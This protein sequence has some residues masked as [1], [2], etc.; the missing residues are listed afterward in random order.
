MVAE[1]GEFGFPLDWEKV[2]GS[3]PDQALGRPHIARVM[4][5]AG[6]VK[7]MGEVF[8]KY[9]GVNG[10]AYVSHQRLTPA[11]AV[12]L[13]LK[14]GGLPVLAHPGCGSGGEIVEELVEAGL[15]GIEAFHSRHTP[16]IIDYYLEVAAK[17]SLL[18]TGGSD[19]HGPREGR[20]ILMG[21]V[22]VPYS[23]VEKMYQM[24]ASIFAESLRA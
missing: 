19:C 20:E 13:V 4:L 5:E 23:T 18:V 12:K 15:I 11:E 10:P 24:K 21:N 8:S 14:V 17:Y 22:T 7:N 2:R 1:L 9:I 16:S 6:Y 3:D